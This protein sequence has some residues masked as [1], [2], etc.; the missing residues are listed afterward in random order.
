MGRLSP[1]WGCSVAAGAGAAAGIAY[2]RSKSF[3]M[4]ERAVAVMIA[5]LV[6]MICDGAKETCALKVGTG[7]IEAYYA[8]MLALRGGLKPPQGVV[9]AL[10]EKTVDNAA[11]LNTEGMTGVDAILIRQMQSR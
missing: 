10:I 6:G 11:R 4:A 2:L 3:E 9:D 1:V 5:D 7:A 8:A